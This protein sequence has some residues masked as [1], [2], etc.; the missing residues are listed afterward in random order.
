ME[1][2]KPVYQ[3]WD[4]A[5]FQMST[6]LKGVSSMKLSRDLNIQQ[7]HAWHLAHKIC[8]TYTES[9]DIFGGTIEVDET[10][11]GGRESK[12]HS[13]KKLNTGCGTVGKSVVAGMKE[14][15]SNEVIR[16]V[17][18]NTKRPTLHGF[19]HDNVTQR[20]EVMTDDLSS[21][22][23]LVDFDH[24]SGRHSVAEYVKQQAHINGIKDLTDSKHTR[25]PAPL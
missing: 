24:M 11:V 13:E 7:K 15:E 20:S 1:S 8:E 25:Q 19:I 3:A 6:N 23:G 2:S 22:Q 5:I 4:I 14:R 21:Y 16:N 17:I 10:Y 18:K 12:K 9:A